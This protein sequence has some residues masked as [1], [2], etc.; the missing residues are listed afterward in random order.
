MGPK[1]ALWSNREKY[2]SA[3]GSYIPFY[4]SHEDETR[5]TDEGDWCTLRGLNF[6]DLLDLGA[7]HKGL[8]NFCWWH[9]I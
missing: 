8:P 4:E 3:D 5:Q 2:P 9:K 1:C 7:N 6:R